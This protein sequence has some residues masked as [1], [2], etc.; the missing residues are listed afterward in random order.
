MIDE[1]SPCSS[2]PFC[3]DGG[4]TFGEQCHFDGGYVGKGVK[5]CPYEDEKEKYEEPD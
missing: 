2:C 4:M 1:N 3:I 5:K